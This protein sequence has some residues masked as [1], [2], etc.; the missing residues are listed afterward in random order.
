V[1]LNG[2]ESHNLLLLIYRLVDIKLLFSLGRRRLCSLNLLERLF[3]FMHSAGDIRQTSRVV[4][5]FPSHAPA[6]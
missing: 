5:A 1:S 6:S 4:F 2:L 3:Q